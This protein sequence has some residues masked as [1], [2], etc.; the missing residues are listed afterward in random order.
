MSKMLELVK[1]IIKKYEGK[2]VNCPCAEHG[3]D[4]DAMVLGSLI[5]SMVDG[6]VWLVPESPYQKF[7]LHDFWYIFGLLD[8][9]TLCS[10]IRAYQWQLASDDHGVRESIQKKVNAL[11]CQV[12]GLDIENFK[13]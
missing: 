1:G 10:K 7:T 5:K 8:I 9:K 6:K 3:S 2:K 11:L 12:T 4:C 13:K